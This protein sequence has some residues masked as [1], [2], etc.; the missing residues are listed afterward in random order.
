MIMTLCGK[1]SYMVQQAAQR[2]IADFITTN[3]SHAVERIAVAELQPQALQSVLAATNMFAPKRMVVI[4]DIELHKDLFAALEDILPTVPE[5]TTVVLWSAELDKRTRGYKFLKANTECTEFALL[6]ERQLVGWVQDTMKE[7]GGV[8]EAPVARFLIQFAGT[9]QWSLQ[10]EIEKL[11]AHGAPIDAESIRAIVTPDLPSNAFNLLDA[12]LAK[13]E[14][15]MYQQL[16]YLRQSADPYEFF[17]LLVWQANALAVIA[18]SPDA[19]R[20]KEAK[21]SPFVIQ[22]SQPIVRQWGRE[23]VRF[24]VRQ[25]VDLDKQIKSGPSDPWLLI[26]QVLYRLIKK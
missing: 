24:F 12:T 4:R 17:G 25:L 2:V 23:G 20:L 16:G 5:E 3:G 15:K 1:N 13:D 22:K 19:A 9:D 8:I 26:E 7:A 10:G 18:F 11:A 6:D 14:H 21:L